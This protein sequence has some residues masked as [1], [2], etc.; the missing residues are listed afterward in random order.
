MKTEPALTDIM[1]G[2][3][4]EM[5]SEVVHQRNDGTGISVMIGLHPV[6][7]SID[8]PEISLGNALVVGSIPRTEIMI[9]TA[10]EDIRQ[11]EARR[12]NEMRQVSEDEVLGEETHPLSVR[13]PS[14]RTAR[15]PLWRVRF[16]SAQAILG[17]NVINWRMPS[18]QDS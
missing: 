11:T 16:V 1:T 5:T 2:T 12:D 14:V 6:T 15:N 4:E 17:G 8:P 7:R 9:A 13:F 3:A 18:K 10:G